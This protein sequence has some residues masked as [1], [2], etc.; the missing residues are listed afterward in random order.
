MYVTLKK[1]DTFAGNFDSM[2]EAQDRARELASP[3][4]LMWRG[5]ADSE[6]YAFG[7]TK[8]NGDRDEYVATWTKGRKPA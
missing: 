3:V 8:A 7:Q 2:V 5:D 4:F 6:A 1:N